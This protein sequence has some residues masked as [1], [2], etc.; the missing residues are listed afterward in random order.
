MPASHHPVPL[1]A[2]VARLVAQLDDNRREAFEERAGILEFDA[3]L[4]RLEAE[5]QALI[6][7][8]ARLGFPAQ[9]IALQAEFGAAARW[10]FVSDE[11]EGRARLLR[12]GASTVVRVDVR[13]VLDTRFGGFAWLSRAV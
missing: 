4:P 1:D 10:V 12:L 3:R 2:G 6:Q 8:L 9:A 7:T 5:R 13:D 11:A